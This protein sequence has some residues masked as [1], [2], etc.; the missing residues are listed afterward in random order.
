MHAPVC[1]WR[2]EDSMGVLVLSFDRVDLGDQNLCRQLGSKCL[3][4]CILP[5]LLLA[6][7]HS[8]FSKFSLFYLC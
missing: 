7:E 1:L 6:F 2:S 3:S 5:A 8:S 4:T